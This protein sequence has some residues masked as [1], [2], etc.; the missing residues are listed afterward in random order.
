MINKE[1]KNKINV[2]SNIN[3]I[4]NTLSM[5]S[6]SKMNKY[7]KYLFILE[8]L[9]IE[10]RNIYSFVYNKKSFINCTIIIT[11]NKGLCGNLNNEIIRKSLNFIKNKKIDIFLIGKKSI[12]YFSKKKIKIENKIIFNDNE[13]ISN[14]FFFKYILKKLINY[15]NIFFINSKFNKKFEIIITNLLEKKINYYNIFNFNKR[16]F[17]FN[18]LNFSI[19]KFFIENFFCE[20]KSRMITMKSA[21]DNSKKIVKDMKI[22]K[23][24][25]R[26]FKVTQEML[27]II[28]GTKL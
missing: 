26:Q 28:N 12:E 3:K 10:S 23:N 21:S 4:T 22:I 15:K 13:K 7:Y 14:I 6:M 11:S 5:I 1:I 27:E 18:F 2:L 16:N 19:K 20:L 24:K 8:N 17:F 25:I 9:F